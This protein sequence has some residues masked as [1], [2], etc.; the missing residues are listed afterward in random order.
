MKKNIVTLVI[1]LFLLTGCAGQQHTVGGAALGGIGGGIAGAQIGKGTGNIAAI[2]GGTLLGAALG[3]YVGSYMD[4]MDN[5][6]YVLLNQTLET[7]PTGQPNQW[8]NP[9]TRTSYRVQPV[10]TYQV[11][12]TGQYCREYQ[13]DVIVGG[14]MQRG[15]GTAC[16]RPDG[17]WEIIK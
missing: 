13:T 7:S 1:V 4:R 17:Q 12:T 15:Y 14:E 6:D 2:I 3:G 10:K 11:Q 9:D 8:H 5:R 16:R